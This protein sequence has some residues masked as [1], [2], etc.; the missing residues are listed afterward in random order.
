MARHRHVK[1]AEFSPADIEP[2]QEMTMPAPFLRRHDPGNGPV[3]E[4]SSMLKLCLT[5]RGVCAWAAKPVRRQHGKKPCPNDRQ[6]EISGTVNGHP[7]AFPIA[8]SGPASRCLPCRR[9]PIQLRLKTAATCRFGADNRR[10]GLA[11]ASAETAA[12]P[13]VGDQ[14]QTHRQS[15]RRCPG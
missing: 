1:E 14:V 7:P 3:A 4:V 13:S 15:A 10:N 11:R 6:P 9:S 5:R 8:P 2:C 12:G